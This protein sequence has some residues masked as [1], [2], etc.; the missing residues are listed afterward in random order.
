M[1]Q[2]IYYWLCDFLYYDPPLLIDMALKW[3]GI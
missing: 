2:K 3:C 1:T